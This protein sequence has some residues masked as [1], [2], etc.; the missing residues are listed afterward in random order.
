MFA[1]WGAEE[2]GLLGSKF[3]V[4]SL[5]EQERKNI[6]LN[7][8]FDMLVSLLVLRKT[9]WGETFNGDFVPH[10]YL[11]FTKLPEGNLQWLWCNFLFD[12]AAMLVVYM[13]YKCCKCVLGVLNQFLVKVHCFPCPQA[14]DSIS[15]E[16]ETIQNV[17]QEYFE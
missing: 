8:N 7:L 11:G 6:S 4:R 12:K 1:F 13:L 5:S 14:D 9:S 16:S 10:F 3:Y 17:L 15:A 2:I